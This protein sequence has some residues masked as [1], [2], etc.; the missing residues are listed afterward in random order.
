MDNFIVSVYSLLGIAAFIGGFKAIDWLIS[1]K[2][3]SRQECNLCM[4]DLVQKQSS[5]S[6]KLTRIET[7]VDMLLE[8]WK[9]EA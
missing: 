6:V 7:K 3:I 8:R 5:E 2:Y 9:N 4:S 1:L